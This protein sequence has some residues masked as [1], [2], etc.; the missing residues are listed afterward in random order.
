[1]WQWKRCTP[2]R[3]SS[4]RY[5]GFLFGQLAVVLRV[6]TLLPEKKKK[7]TDMTMNQNQG[8]LV[9]THAVQLTSSRLCRLSLLLSANFDELPEG[10]AATSGHR[11]E[12]TINRGKDR[13]GGQEELRAVGKPSHWCG[14]ET[15]PTE[16]RVKLDL[17]H[18]QSL[19][20]P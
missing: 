19:G 10:N 5:G 12:T 17:D 15:E 20:K 14:Q 8:I 7:P 9:K 11:K 13:G 18:I 4:D 3:Y 6:L 1:M 2:S 16:G